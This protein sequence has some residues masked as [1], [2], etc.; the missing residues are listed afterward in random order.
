VEMTTDGCGAKSMTKPQHVIAWS[1]LLISL[2]RIDDYADSRT[3]ILPDHH[4]N[5]TISVGRHCSPFQWAKH[6]L[7]ATVTDRSLRL[8][9]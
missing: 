9:Y 5:A 7:G 4:D 1:G 3:Y 8:P 2:V 6:M